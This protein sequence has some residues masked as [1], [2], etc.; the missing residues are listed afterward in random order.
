MWITRE[1]DG[2]VER[3]GEEKLLGLK[4]TGTARCGVEGTG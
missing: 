1:G 3:R 4:K 2:S